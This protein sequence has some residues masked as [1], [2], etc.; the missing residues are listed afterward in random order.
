MA[1]PRDPGLVRIVDG[2]GYDRASPDLHHDAAVRLLV[3]RGAH[4]VDLALEPEQ[5]AGERQGA[6]PLAGSCLGGEPRDAGLLVVEGLGDG[7]VRLVGPG[8]GH[9]LVLV[10]DAGGRAEGALQPFGAD[11]RGRA[12]QPQHV[13]HLAGDV[14][15]GLG[16]D[17]LADECH[18]EQGGEVVG[19]ERLAGTWVKVRLQ[20]LGQLRHDVEPRLGHLS[21]W[22]VPAHRR[23]PF[24][25][26]R[27]WMKAHCSEPE[28]L[29]RRNYAG[30]VDVSIGRDGKSSLHR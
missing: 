18:R 27:N 25:A 20:S 14:D 8:G 29:A 21:G 3:V 17:L 7:G 9:R 13:D 15:P 5:R 4:H 1:E 28:P 2:G 26:G 10:V 22:K 6:A 30:R 24:S 16:G 11:E 19:A 23:L 12:P